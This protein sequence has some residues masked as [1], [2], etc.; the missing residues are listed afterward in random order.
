[1][2]VYFLR[3]RSPFSVADPGFPR[4]GGTN[5]PWEGPPTYDFVKISQKLHEIERIW[6]G[7]GG[8]RRA[9]LDPPLRLDPW[10]MNIVLNA[11]D[12]RSKVQSGRGSISLT[13]CVERWCDCSCP[14]LLLE[15]GLFNTQ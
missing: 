9:P 8:G 5:S 14:L 1:M 6:T 13:V 7:G 3:T 10:Y 15:P 2:F 4:G 11:I 12:F